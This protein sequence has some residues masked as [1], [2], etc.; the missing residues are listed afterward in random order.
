MRDFDTLVELA[1][2]QHG[3]VRTEDVVGAGVASSTLRRFR[4]DG[5]VERLAQGLYR[6]VAV[7]SD[8][9][10]PY[11]VAVMWANGS[12]VVSH[13]SAL[14]MLELCDINPRRIHITVPEAYNPRR[15]GGEGFRVHRNDLPAQDMTQFEGVPV[16]STFRAIKQSLDDGEDPQQVRLAIRNATAR[17]ML[18]RPEAARLWARLRR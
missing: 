15:A 12:G 14:E 11:L 5:R 7:P 17:G 13:G 8:R 10:T 1:A 9:M 18:L 16:V 3:L 4:R 6:V 2:D